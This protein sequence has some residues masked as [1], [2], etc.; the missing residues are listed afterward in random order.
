M[1]KLITVVLSLICAIGMV[2]CKPDGTTELIKLGEVS[3][4]VS[5]KGYTGED[6]KEKLVGQFNEDIIRSWGTPDFDIS[7][8]GSQYEHPGWAQG[9]Y[10]DDD[11]YQRITLYLGETG[12]VEEII[13][14]TNE[15]K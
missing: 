3:A 10:L 2:G 5:E 1:K 8:F 14:D 9:W 15:G 12:F 4:L 13:I 11:N 7:G 6:F